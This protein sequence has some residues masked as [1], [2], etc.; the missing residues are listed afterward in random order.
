MVLASRLTGCRRRNE[1]QLCAPS[2]EAPIKAVPV[3]TSWVRTTADGERLLQL[4]LFSN[5]DPGLVSN[6][7]FGLISPA[8]YTTAD[9][10]AIDTIGLHHMT[11]M[12]GLHSMKV[13]VS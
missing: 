7:Q 10:F 13:F 1:Q 4:H 11:K 5:Q 2:A 6:V 3:L 8:F 12:L 9:G